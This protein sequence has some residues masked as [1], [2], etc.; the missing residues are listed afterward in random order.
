[1]N[2]CLRSKGKNDAEKRALD[3]LTILSSFMEHENSQVRT[4]VNG[5][6]Y[7]ILSRATIKEKALEIGM[8]EILRRVGEVLSSSFFVSSY[9]FSVSL[10]DCRGKQ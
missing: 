8:D 9:L 3:M 10:P 6:L 2:L 7:S 5:T 4:Y 1:M